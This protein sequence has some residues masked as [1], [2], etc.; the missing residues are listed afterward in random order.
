MDFE[1]FRG[2]PGELRYPGLWTIWGAKYMGFAMI[3]GV[4]VPECLMHGF[5][6][7]LGG[8]GELRNPG[9]R[10]IQD[11]KYMEFAMIGGRGAGDGRYPGYLGS[12]GVKCIDFG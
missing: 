11:A 4:G 8:P 3:G 5:W 6:I 7:I 12:Q 10:T 2:G 1:S 9:L